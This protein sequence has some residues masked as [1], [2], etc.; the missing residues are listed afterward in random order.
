MSF[1]K[2]FNNLDTKRNFVSLGANRFLKLGQDIDG[3][4][5]LDNFGYSVSI[6]AA[7]DRVAIGAWAND[8]N[9]TKTDAGHVRVYSW[10]GMAWTQL[11]A[12]IDGEG[13]FDYS[14]FSVSM[15]S[16]GDRVAIGA[17]YND[18]DGAKGDAGHVRV[19]SWDG[20]AWTQLGIDI[21]GEAINDS[22]GIS[23]SMNAAGDR[24]AIGAI[25]NDANGKLSAGHVRIYSWD[26]TV[27]TQLGVDIDGEEIGDESGRSVSMNAAGD[28]VA[29][30]APYN[31]VGGTKTDAGHVR[32]YSWNGIA[33]TQLGANING[34]VAGDYSGWSVSM[35]AAGDRV[36]IGAWAND[37][38]GA[39]TD[40]GHVRVYSW[41]GTVWT[42]LGTDIDGEATGDS[43]GISV[44]MNAV[45]D[46]VAIGANGNNGNGNDSGH[47]R[48]Y[49]WNGTNWTQLGVDING[50]AAGDESGK[51]VSM[52][53]AGD[54]VAIG[55]NGNDGNGNDSGHVRIY[56][57]YMYYDK[58]DIWKDIAA[59]PAV[60]FAMTPDNLAY[61]VV[62]PTL[63]GAEIN[64]STNSGATWSTWYLTTNSRQA[65]AVAVNSNAG[66][67][68]ITTF[69][70]RIYVGW[71]NSWT[72][73]DV[74]RGWTDVAISSNGTII[75]ALDYGGFIYVSTNGG[76]NWTA[77]GTLQLAWQAVAMSSNGVIQTAVDYFGRI[78]V[79][80]DTGNTWAARESARNWI[81]IAMSSDGVIQTA[82]VAS[83]RIY[84]STDTGNTWTERE[85]VRNWKGIAMSSDGV[86]QTATVN[87]G[88]IYV[89][90][91]TGT[92]WSVKQ[93]V[94]GWTSVAISSNGAIQLAIADSYL[95]YR[96]S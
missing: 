88:Q 64:Y 12:D 7:G 72:A 44:S 73:R 91:D 24:V 60:D 52:N 96:S 67:A 80:T 59:F 9:G 17:R 49:A 65:T 39:K 27:W 70:G 32:I 31:D 61:I 56:K 95:L 28:R 71:G 66:R 84:V 90:T 40:A 37:V 29:I 8:V 53:A 63:G 87:G 10:N 86:I 1:F 78:Y 22:S 3:E 51:S 41:N 93:S 21:D 43:S 5:T 38:N 89:S 4:M 30:G 55:A 46:R 50:E 83:G 23:V 62:G 94:R 2:K 11:G 75:T 48:I 25:A 15:N 82:I 47:V 77:R 45:G 18:V 42:Q 69:N 20:I 19:Y 6:N 14:G 36:A 92:T 35:N 58:I 57:D 13:A 16:V 76:V 68:V 33:W 79:S 34:D 74:D 85:S 81:G 54:R 26:G